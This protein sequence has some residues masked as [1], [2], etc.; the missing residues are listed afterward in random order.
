MGAEKAHGPVK[1][2]LAVLY[3]DPGVYLKIRRALVSRLGPADLESRP[4]DFHYTGYYDREMGRP[5]TRVFLS[6]RKLMPPE[7]LARIKRWTNRLEKKHSENGRRRVNLDPGYMEMGKFVLATTKD[8]QHRLYIG[9]GIFEEVTLYYRDKK[10]RAWDWT[11]PDYRSPEYHEIL[12]EIR[13][14]YAAQRD[15]PAR[16]TGRVQA[17]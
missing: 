8:Q 10:W 6:F 9:G 17:P 16:L 2:V 5:I 14:L 1:P 12:E 3:S 13:E 11:Y 4:L 15:A 7:K